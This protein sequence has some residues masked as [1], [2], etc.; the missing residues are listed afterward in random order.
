MRGMRL[1]TRPIIGSWHVFTHESSQPLAEAGTLPMPISQMGNR[2]RS[3]FE[4]SIAMVLGQ[5]DIPGASI[6]SLQQRER[7][8]KTCQEEQREEDLPARTACRGYLNRC[9]LEEKTCG[10]R[11]CALK[12]FFCQSHWLCSGLEGH[13]GG[14]PA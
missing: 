1:C 3:P 7:G 4:L 14:G 10:L 5:A 13:G 12:L 6:S 8:G 2:G 11:G 9:L